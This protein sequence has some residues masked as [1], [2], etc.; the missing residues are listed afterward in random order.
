[1]ID[2]NTGD[3]TDRIL[4]E[5]TDFLNDVATGRDGAFLVSNSR[6]K[7]IFAVKDGAATVWLQDDRLEWLNGLHNDGERLLV[8]TMPRGELLAVDWE[9][10]AITGLASGMENADG[11]G[12]RNDGSYIISSWPGQLWHVHDGETPT[13]LQD[14]SGETSAVMMND[15]LLVNGETLVTPNWMPGTV[16]AYG[17][18]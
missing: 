9:T 8:A 12:I 6:T 15:I 11:I 4:I 2:T 14:T 13:L 16:R 10:K 1:M 18:E 7:T 17:V 3:I 5:G